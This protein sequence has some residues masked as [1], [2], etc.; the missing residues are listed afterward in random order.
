MSSAEV[1][2]KCLLS[3][4]YNLENNK[5]YVNELNVFPVPDGDTGTNMSLTMRS[6]VKN[7]TEA[8]EISVTTIA[9]AASNGSLMGAR[10]NSG[11]ILSQIL[12]GF[13]KGFKGQDEI[14]P[15]VLR[16]GFVKA[17]ETAYKAVMKPTEGTILTV[18]REM[19]EFAEKNVDL[20]ED[21]MPFLREIIAKGNESLQNTPNLLPVLKEAGVVDSGGKGLM[22]ILEGC[23]NYSEEKFIPE[24][25]PT[26][27]KKT[28]ASVQATEEI[29]F[30]YC[31]EFLIQA[32]HVNENKFR[33]K[34]TPL[35]DCIIVVKGD[36]I[37]KTHIHTNHPGRVLELA[38]EEGALKDIKI[39][40]M[41][42]QHKHI[43]AS[44]N[45]IEGAKQ[46]EIRVKQE[47]KKYAFI[48][49][50]SG[51]GLNRVFE[52]LGVDRIIM[53]GQTMNPSTE[54]ISKVVEELSADHI[55][56][57]PNNKNI[58][59]SA[60]QTKKLSDKDVHVL[61]T[62]SIPQGI[63][64]LISFDAGRDVKEN[65]A[66]MEEA[67]SEIRSGQVTYSVRDT[68]IGNIDVKKDDIIGLDEKEIRAV[69]K[70]I[71]KVS[72][73][74]ISQLIQPDS[75]L[76]TLYYGD[77]VDENTAQKL[78]EMLEE[79]F[80]DLDIEIIEGTQPI[81]YYIISVE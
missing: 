11:V 41:R 71:N 66:S 77:G 3:G 32:D 6:A 60:N 44:D 5:E 33:E 15:L 43:L 50:S 23:L 1:L 57:L 14:T 81:Y 27:M 55:F 64:A 35:G 73:D 45:E 59:M 29:E 40:N 36:G 28:S 22:V 53:G 75:D 34:I 70:D 79:K 68:K 67:I 78:R 17:Y 24:G 62:R 56:I 25:T 31:T 19:G 72:F 18:I 26:E 54:D 16:D 48:T 47:H 58:I 38:L 46:K 8:R 20:F 37:V 7:I 42:F 13:Y 63:A 69:G 10:G 21:T 30:G 80:E 61:E 39:E 49:I 74:L 4:Y 9:K 2:K 76:V 52:S 65:I 12:R 51:K